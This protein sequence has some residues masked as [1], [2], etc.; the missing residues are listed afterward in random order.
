MEGQ[1][2]WF[3][4]KKGYGFIETENQRNVF[5]H[6]RIVERPLALGEILQVEVENGP[7]GP[8]VI[9]AYPSPQSPFSV[10]Q[11]GRCYTNTGH[12]LYIPRW[13]RVKTWEI[14]YGYLPGRGHEAL[15]R[16]S[17]IGLRAYW[18]RVNGFHMEAVVIGPPTNILWG[19]VRSTYSPWDKDL[20]EAGWSSEEIEKA[21]QWL[22]AGREGGRQPSYWP[23]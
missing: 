4:E 20:R 9:A 13:A 8:Y 12:R 10:V 19:Q 14:N 3:D 7:R 6:R 23:A 15:V 11:A 2:K 22:E 21:V 18:S 1:V 5:I 17:T 16:T